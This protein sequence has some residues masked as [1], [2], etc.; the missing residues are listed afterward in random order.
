MSKIKRQFPQRT[1]RI[2]KGINVPQNTYVYKV[3][4]K[5]VGDDGRLLKNLSDHLNIEYVQIDHSV[6]TSLKNHE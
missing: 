3:V 4:F 6:S 5:D 2:P 1:Q